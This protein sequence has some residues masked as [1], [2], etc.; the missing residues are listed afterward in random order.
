V[1]RAIAGVAPGDRASDEELTPDDEE[2]ELEET[3]IE[4]EVDIVEGGSTQL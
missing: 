2:A 4:A 3:E 1:G